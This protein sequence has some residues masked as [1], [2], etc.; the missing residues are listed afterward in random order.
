MLSIGLIYARFVGFNKINCHKLMR[1]FSE[2]EYDGISHQFLPKSDE[3]YRINVD[4]FKFVKW[5]LAL[6]DALLLAS[7]TIQLLCS[8]KLG[9]ATDRHTNKIHKG[10]FLNALKIHEYRYAR[11]CFST[12]FMTNVNKLNSYKLLFY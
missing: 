5:F 1:D 3:L 10:F 12:Y 9:L 4:L 8:R 2:C 6:P 11:H 7:R